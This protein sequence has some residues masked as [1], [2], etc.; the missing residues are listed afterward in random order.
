VAGGEANLVNA[1]RRPI[2]PRDES[3][4]TAASGASPS[5]NHS[6]EALLHARGELL[7]HDALFGSPGGLDDELNETLGDFIAVVRESRLRLAELAE[8]LAE[9]DDTIAS[10]KAKVRILEARL[11]L[12]VSVSAAGPRPAQSAVSSTERSASAQAKTIGIW[13]RLTGLEHY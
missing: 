5:A 8:A 7:A 9:R 1:Q 3:F 13:R 11:G 4:G 2:D 12:S 10:L 6:S